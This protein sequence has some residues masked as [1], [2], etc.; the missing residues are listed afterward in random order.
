MMREITLFTAL[1]FRRIYDT[2]GEQALIL[3]T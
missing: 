2:T 3:L 1:S